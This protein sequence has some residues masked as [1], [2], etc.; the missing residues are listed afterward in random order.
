M[1]LSLNSR[2]LPLALAPAPPPEAQVQVCTSCA[3]LSDSREFGPCWDFSSPVTFLRRMSFPQRPPALW[4]A[5]YLHLPQPPGLA[6]PSQ[7]GMVV[8]GG[9]WW[10]KRGLGWEREAFTPPLLS[11][12]PVPPP[13]PRPGRAASPDPE[14]PLNPQAL[15]SRYPGRGTRRGLRS[16]SGP[17]AL[18]GCWRGFPCG[19]EHFFLFSRQGPGWL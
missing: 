1:S 17:Q 5:G 7:G 6:V 8:A 3:P 10:I 12:S 14:P 2:F 11:G 19:H 15:A 9:V 18:C 13:S 16:S 4:L